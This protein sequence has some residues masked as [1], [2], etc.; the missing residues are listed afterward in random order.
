ML[1]EFC[2]GFLRSPF[3]QIEFVTRA[4][5]VEP[6]EIFKSEFVVWNDRDV[7]EC[8]CRFGCPYPFEFPVFHE[9]SQLAR[10]CIVQSDDDTV[11]VQGVVDDVN[12]ALRLIFSDFSF[13]KYDFMIWL[14][15]WL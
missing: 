14:V 4:N 5:V 1:F 10:F 7:V 6:R 9:H 3:E 2:A 12:V 13:S 11:L 15:T 8:T